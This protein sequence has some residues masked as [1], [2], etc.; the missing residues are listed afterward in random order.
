MTFTDRI[1]RRIYN[2]I[3]ELRKIRSSVHFER[4]DNRIIIVCG[5]IKIKLPDNY[6]FCSPIISIDNIP[7]LYTLH[8]PSER[9]SYAINR[10]M[11]KPTCLCCESLIGH[12]KQWIPVLTILDVFQEI[13]N[14]NE[15][16]R[17]VAI[18][19][20]L[21]EILNRYQLTDLFVPIY[22]FLFKT[23]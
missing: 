6:P 12:K 4:V 20:I 9:I 14:Y 10:I 8:S 22:S 23:V 19:L 5:N 2:E 15:L 16:K 1:K 3:K 17:K 11:N 21:P 7:Y 18:H 13:D